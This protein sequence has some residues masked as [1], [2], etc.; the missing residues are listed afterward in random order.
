MTVATRGEGRQVRS[1]VRRRLSPMERWYWIC[2][3]IS[4]LNV[5]ARVHI[6]GVCAAEDLERASAQ[7]AAEHPL[8]RVAVAAAPDGSCP[9]FV[10]AQD[11][12]LPIRTARSAGDDADRW[13]REVDEVELACSLDWRAGPLAR[14]VDVVRVDPETAD[15]RHDLILT[16][17][18]VIADGTTALELLRRLVEL[19]AKGGPD[20]GATSW[21]PLA[22]REPLPPPES[23]LP[24][25]VNGLPRAV[26]LVAALA[27]DA[28][29]TAVA[30]PRRLRLRPVT[31]VA[32]NRRRTR[33]I[34]RELDAAQLEE[35]TSRCRSERATVHSALAAAMAIAVGNVDARTRRVSIGSPV[36]FRAELV[37]PVG[38]R[39]AGAY[40]ATVPTHIRVGP[41][42]DLWTAARGAAR[43]LRRRR[44]FGHHLALVS[45]LRL[46]SPRSVG[47]SARAVSAVDWMGLGNVCLANMGRFDYPDRVGWWE[48]SGAQ[49]VV[50]VSVSGYLVATASTS[51]GVLHWNFAY[52]DGAVTRERAEQ[53]ADRAVQALLAKD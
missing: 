51:H 50:G 20:A 44:R 13:V 4:P 49:L 11:A 19:A 10:A 26:H 43:V 37:P 46:M 24:K 38:Q 21:A 2:D 34:R 25:R 28:I 12:R 40:V 33:L 8:L 39:D 53:I 18:H 42:V 29:S 35:L 3:Q 15:E 16:A 36:D 45:L 48:I 5:I 17:S 7:L 14:I 27:A 31:P 22:P 1:Q 23:M 30:W 41:C 9:R 47:Q 52:V 32:P 6:A